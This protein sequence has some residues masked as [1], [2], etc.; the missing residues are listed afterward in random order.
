MSTPVLRFLSLEDARGTGL[1]IQNPRSRTGFL[2]ILIDTKTL[3]AVLSIRERRGPWN[4]VIGYDVVPLTDHLFRGNQTTWAQASMRIETIRGELRQMRRGQ[5]EAQQPD[6]KRQEQI[7]DIRE[8]IDTFRFRHVPELVSTFNALPS[9]L[10]MGAL[11]KIVWS[12]DEATCAW[13]NKLLNIEQLPQLHQEVMKEAESLRERFRQF[14]HVH[15]NI[16]PFLKNMQA[17]RAAFNALPE[18]SQPSEDQFA[19]IIFPL[20]VQLDDWEERTEELTLD[21]IQA[22]LPFF[23]LQLDLLQKELAKDALLREAMEIGYK[24]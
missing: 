17:M 24:Q 21:E 3:G 8:Q 1:Q 16:T 9:P 12:A 11:S 4:M 18:D 20:Q 10:L 2:H 15:E 13:E 6:A 22:K 23:Q 7:R 14:C 5:I 19:A